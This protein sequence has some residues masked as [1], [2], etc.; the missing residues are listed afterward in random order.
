MEIKNKKS[1][2]KGGRKKRG[3][4]FLGR[5][6]IWESHFYVEIKKLPH[7]SREEKNGRRVWNKR[8]QLLIR[9]WN[10][11]MSHCA[12]EICATTASKQKTTHMYT[13]LYISI[14][15]NSILKIK[16]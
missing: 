1:R 15:I 5:H 8:R 9:S 11:E 14:H 3:Y 2:R 12:P 10:T 13:L 16:K 6:L 7:V 4:P